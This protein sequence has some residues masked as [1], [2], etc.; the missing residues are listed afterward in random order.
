MDI[1]DCWRRF[2]AD[3][4]PTIQALECVFAA[5]LQVVVRLA[6]IAAFFMLVAGGFKYLTAGGDPKKAESARNTLTYAVMGLAV[7]IG[8]WFIMLLIEKLTGVKVT[9][10]SII[11][12][13]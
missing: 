8:S 9:E 13:P 12:T 6:G 7:L 10:F 2:S 4:V 11:P 5:V 1:G 3:D